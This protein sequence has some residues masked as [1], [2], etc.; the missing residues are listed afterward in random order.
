MQSYKVIVHDGYLGETGF[1][2]EVQK[3]AVHVD[4]ISPGS[5]NCSE[6]QSLS[7]PCFAMPVP[8]SMEKP[9][10]MHGMTYGSKVCRE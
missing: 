1:V 2:L 4:A 6:D 3:V 5:H 7:H 9:R 10:Y 8:G